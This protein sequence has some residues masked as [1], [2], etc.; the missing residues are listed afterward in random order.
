MEGIFYTKQQQITRPVTLLQIQQDL[1]RNDI[2]GY[3][4]W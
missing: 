1:E 2:F 4:Y 3:V